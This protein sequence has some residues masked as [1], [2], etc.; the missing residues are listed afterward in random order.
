MRALRVALIGSR[1]IPGRYG[2]YETLFT[3]LA[4]RLVARGFRAGPL[5]FLGGPVQPARREAAAQGGKG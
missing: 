3:E 2:G 5:E 4:P 1:G